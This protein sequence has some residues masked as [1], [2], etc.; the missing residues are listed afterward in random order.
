MKNRVFVLLAMLLLVCSASAMTLPA[1]LQTIE[2]SAFEGD[3]SLRGVIALPEGVKAVGSR[4][5]AGTSVHALIVPEGCMTLEADVLSGC[6]AAYVLLE[7]KDTVIS[8]DALSGVS[9]VFGPAEGSASTQS[10]F[11]A[12]ETLVKQSGFYFTVTTDCATPLCAVDGTAVSGTVTLPKFVEGVPVRSLGSLTLAGCDSLTGLRVPSYL[13]CPSGLNAVAYDAMTVSVPVTAATDVHTGMSL[14]WTTGVTG[15]YGDVAYIWN[16]DVDG[17]VTSLITAEPSVTWSPTTEGT[18]VVSVTAVDALEDSATATA[19]GIAVAPA[20]P[21]YRALLIGNIYAGTSMQLDG[22]DT[23]AAA[24]RTMLSGMTGTDY[25]VTTCIDLTAAQIRS[26]IASAFADANS[27]D[28]SLFYF[29]GHGSSNG[30]LVGTDRYGVSPST[31]RTCLDAIPGT[32]IVIIDA[33]YSGSMI[34]KSTEEVSPSAF[35]SAFISAFSAYSKDDLA[36]NGYQ[37]M[38]ACSKDQLSQSLSD[39]TISFGAFTYGVTYGSG[40]DEWKQKLLGSL[41]ADTNSDGA[42]TLSEAYAK[43]VER[44]AWLG[45]MVDINQSAQYYGDSGFILWSK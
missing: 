21:V 42:I 2:D 34:G 6:Q 32:K 11:F 27:N 5:F 3:A 30:S 14:T 15:A 33:C 40:Y 1:D 38:T 17:V 7:G 44:V 25:S 29:S 31:L 24:M 12:S 19:E 13:T 20:A 37:V 22:C 39:G 16:F 26:A 36:T 41:P 43:A 4:A 8:G 23:D 35:T 45:T 18:C 10:G 28:V 9:F